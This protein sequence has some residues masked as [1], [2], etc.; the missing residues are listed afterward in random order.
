MP[1]TSKGAMEEL[2]FYNKIHADIMP[3]FLHITLF[4]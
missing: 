4:D 3:G 2:L 1:S